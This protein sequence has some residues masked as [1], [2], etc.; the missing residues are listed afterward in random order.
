MQLSVLRSLGIEV[1][2]LGIEALD[3]SRRIAEFGFKNMSNESA[4][5][6][7]NLCEV[8]IVRIAR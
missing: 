5:E 1:L 3:A 2:D 7:L 8:F 4:V 6:R